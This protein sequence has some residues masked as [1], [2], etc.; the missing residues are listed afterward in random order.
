MDLQ[1][2]RQYKA[3]KAGFQDILHIL[4]HESAWIDF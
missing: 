4:F 3:K 2:V 1:A